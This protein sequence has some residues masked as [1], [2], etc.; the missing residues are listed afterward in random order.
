[1]AA[2]AA[3]VLSLVASP[4]PDGMERV[5][6]D[7]GI[8]PAPGADFGP[9]AGLAGTLLALGLAWAA[10]RLLTARRKS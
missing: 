3:G 1:M 7:A 10:L 5:L 8:R 9:L 6:E 2:V 4:L